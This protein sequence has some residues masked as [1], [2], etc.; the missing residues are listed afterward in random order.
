MVKTIQIQYYTTYLTRKKER[1]SAKRNSAS[2][3][4]QYMLSLRLLTRYCLHLLN[5]STQSFALNFPLFNF[6]LYIN[7]L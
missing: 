4:D 2:T 3:E 1:E 6:I 7:R 5:F